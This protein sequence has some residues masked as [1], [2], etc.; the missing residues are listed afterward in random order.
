MTA[1]LIIDAVRTPLGRR[2]GALARVHPA[3]LLADLF[4]AVAARNGL[5]PSVIDDV[6]VGCMEQ[7]GEQSNTIGRVAWLTAGFPETVPATTIERQC[8]SSQQALHFAAQGIAAGAYDAVVVAG[9]ESMSRVPIGS[10]TNG[11]GSWI[12]D[13]FRD[14][15]PDVE[16][17]GGADLTQFDSADLIAT[18]WAISRLAT[19]EYA[20]RSHQLAAAATD[21]GAFN[22]ELVPVF[23]AGAGAT[24]PLLLVDEGI[25]R[26]S[27]LERM[28]TLEPVRDG[29]V[30][31]AATSSQISDGASAILLMSEQR[32]EQLGCRPRAKIVGGTAVGHDFREGLTAPI[33]ATHQVLRTAGLTLNDLGA[34][35]VNE[36]FASVVLAWKE[37]V[38]ATDEWFDSHVNPRGGALAIG[39]PIGCSGVRLMVTLLHE[40]EDSGGRYGLQTMCGSHGLGTAT[41]I[42]TLDS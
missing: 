41:V 21:S 29:G 2:G 30:T 17:F 15:Y 12:P 6:L 33:P 42:E 36:A 1:A 14:R 28:A 37:A 24:S 32:A 10:S 31:T 38:G 25:R 9:V 5:D 40:L 23:E 16:G 18:R 4:I 22:R 26:N 11:P 8:C 20:L 27:T 34:V 3:D 39:H 35:E 19:E 13:R 7:L